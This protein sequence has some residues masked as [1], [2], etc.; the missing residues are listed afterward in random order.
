MNRHVSLLKYLV[1]VMLFVVF[2]KQMASKIVPS[3]GLNNGG[4]KRVVLPQVLRSGGGALDTDGDGIPDWF[5]ERVFM[6]KFNPADAL[7]RRYDGSMTALEKYEASADWRVVDTAGDGIADAWKL[8]YLIN[9]LLDIGEIIATNG[10]TF[11]DSYVRG[12]NP[13]VLTQNPA[14][15]GLTDGEILRL[16]FSPF[17]VV[18]IGATNVLTGDRK[19]TRL[20]SSH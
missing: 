11:F 14:N 6:D 7:S 4:G 2:S 18:P 12:L 1:F 9:P 10:V 16:G 8:Q 5:E 15:V 20:N 17:E 13:L 3:S 19:S